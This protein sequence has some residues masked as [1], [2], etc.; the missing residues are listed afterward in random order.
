MVFSYILVVVLNMNPFVMQVAGIYDT[1]AECQ[2]NIP[3]V[4]KAV[5]NA[6][7]VVC[8]AKVRDYK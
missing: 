1:S 7:P 6:A 3:V 5:K 4:E 8:F 2:K